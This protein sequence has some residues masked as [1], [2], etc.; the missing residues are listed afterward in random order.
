M[1][2]PACIGGKKGDHFM[3]PKPDYEVA[4]DQFEEAD[5]AYKDMEERLTSGMVL[6][7]CLVTATRSGTVSPEIMRREFQAFMTSLRG[8]LEDRNAK[9]KTAQ[10]LLR[11]AVVLTESQWRGST[12]RPT[13]VTYK[14]FESSS[15]T[16]RTFDPKSLMDGA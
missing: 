2:A 1:S 13:R 8:A 5:R 7:E 6:E 15:V 11:Q 3:P 12:G 14:G 4:V 10:D 16:H 9:L